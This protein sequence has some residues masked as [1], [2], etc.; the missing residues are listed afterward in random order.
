MDRR[1]AALVVVGLSGVVVADRFAAIDTQPDRGDVEPDERDDDGDQSGKG[2]HRGP[3]V[4]V[5]N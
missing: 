4:P 3:P 2:V 5:H 1:S